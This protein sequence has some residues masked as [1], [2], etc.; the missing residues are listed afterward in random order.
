MDLSRRFFL[1]SAAAPIMAG[2]A[3]VAQAQAAMEGKKYRA[4][5]IG[6]TKQG[7]YGHFM[8]LVF[9]HRPDV[10]VVALADPDEQGRAQNAAECGAKTTYADYREMLEKEK[11][12][13]VSIGP[14]CT[15]NHKEY[16][17]A[18]AAVGAHGI[19][20]KP[21]STDLA[22]ADEMIAA[23]DAKN[24]K[25]SIAFN[26]RVSPI[27]QHAKK[28]LLEDRIIGSVLEVRGRGKEDNR[29]GAED[30]IVLGT[31]IFDAM[32]FL[33]D[34]KPAWCESD[35]TVNGKPATKADVHEASEP[36]GPIVGNRLHSVYGYSLGTAGHFS[37]MKSKD[38]PGGRFGLDVYGSLGIMTIRVD[39]IPQVYV[40]RDPTWAP[41]GSG[42]QWEPL[43]GAPEVKMDDPR[44]GRNA[45]IIDDLI[46]A[47]QENR[48]P[49]VS[50]KHGRDSLEMIQ[51]TFESYVQ[52]K[53]V[54][55]PLQ[56]RVHPLK[57]WA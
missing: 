31:H 39:V 41:G 3:R 7:G 47:I 1:A 46:A 12:D 50:L 10:E 52:G 48:E 49:Q 20:E 8:H 6:D 30:M 33:M 51:A 57:R 9:A 15:V 11:P 35:I 16:V 25:W 4:C 54:A 32:S 27:L 38:G 13:L 42:A 40:L 19:I 17:L 24:L 37:S 22:E 2:A 28:A 44:N 18:A 56:E 5:I 45:P 21:I 26:F 14:R 29:A 43:P 53:R 36:L 34:G 55:M 23:L